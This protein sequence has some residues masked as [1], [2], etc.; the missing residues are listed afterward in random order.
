[1]RKQIWKRFVFII[2][3][4]FI[5]IMITTGCGLENQDPGTTQLP[6]N[7]NDVITSENKDSTM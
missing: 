2:V 5:T 6:T 4:L 3:I 7:S 1:M